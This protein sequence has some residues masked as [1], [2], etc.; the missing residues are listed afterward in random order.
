MEEIASLRATLDE[1]KRRSDHA[2]P[3]PP[4]T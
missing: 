4:D 1:Y 3:Q 2:V